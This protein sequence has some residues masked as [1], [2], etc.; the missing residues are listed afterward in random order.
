MSDHPDSADYF[1][2]DGTGSDTVIIGTVEI[3]RELVVI[4]LNHQV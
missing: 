3:Q 1:D 2:G 4:H